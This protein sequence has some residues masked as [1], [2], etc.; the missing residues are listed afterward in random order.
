MSLTSIVEHTTPTSGSV[1]LTPRK[2]RKPS[3]ERPNDTVPTNADIF[4]WVLT[5]EATASC[6]VRDVLNMQQKPG[7]DFL[8]LERVPCRNVRLVGL[9]VGVQILEKKIIYSVDDGTSVIDCQHKCTNAP[10][11]PTKPSQSKSKIKP[12]PGN[13]TW[14]LVQFPKPLA[15]VGDH[16]R[17]CGKVAQ[18]FESRQIIATT[19]EK[20]S[21]NDQP[22]H[23]KEVLK[24]HSTYYSLSEP[25]IIPTPVFHPPEPN[26]RAMQ[27]VS[28]PATSGAP[29]PTKSTASSH[30]SPRKLRHPSKLRS[31]DLTDI[32]FRI[33]VKH[34]MDC[35]HSMFNPGPDT[36]N[37]GEDSDFPYPA[38]PTKCSRHPRLDDQTPRR[39]TYTNTEETP[40]S[41]RIPASLSSNIL[42]RSPPDASSPQL[43]GFTLSFLRRVPELNDMGKRVVKAEAKRRAKEAAKKAA[44]DASQKGR[45]GACIPSTSTAISRPEVSTAARMKRLW[46]STILHLAKEGS[47]VLWDGPVYPIPSNDE[48]V[49]GPWRSDTGISQSFFH[50]LN[51]TANTSGMSVFSSATERP[52]DDQ[53]DEEIG[54]S[55]PEPGEESYVSLTPRYFSIEVEKA[56]RV[57]SAGSRAQSKSTGKMVPGPTKQSILVYFRRDDRWRQ[58]GEW[59]VQ[60]AL[61]VLRDEG[62]AWDDR[63]G[64]WDLVL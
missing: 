19:I 18:H 43:R 51:A 56:I 47:I 29:S 48:T 2:R 21:S 55:D 54:L 37:E 5:P 42:D 39:S 64:V 28:S 16:V 59:N 23:W 25:F 46:R 35:Y 17:V 12:Q 58:I 11:S 60:E 36:T 41:S 49:A 24:L 44:A 33:Y 10:P 4:N 15:C 30:Q 26:R 7:E 20:C 6:F 63:H 57:L 13:R 32:T 14:S 62:R 61:D 1:L 22:L 27:E 31:R 45:G 40:R 52:L 34:F 8:W 53:D 3:A 38:T 50:S 9:I